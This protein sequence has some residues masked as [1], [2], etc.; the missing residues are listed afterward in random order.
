[1]IERDFISGFIFGCLLTLGIT[2]AVAWAY[3]RVTRLPSPSGVMPPP[4]APLPYTMTSE[5]NE[6]KIERQYFSDGPAGLGR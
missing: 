4:A 2:Y 6:A 1:M 3:S 5:A